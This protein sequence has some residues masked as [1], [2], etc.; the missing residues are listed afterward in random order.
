MTYNILQG[1][2]KEVLATIPDNFYDGCFCDPP[3]GLHFMGKKWDYD[4]P[5]KDTW[6]EVYRILKPG[7]Y[8]LAFGG[9]RT[10]HRLVCEIEDAGFIVR[11]SLTWLFGS[12]FP[13]SHNISKDMDKRG[14]NNHISKEIGI[15]IKEARESRGLTIKECDD[16][17]CNSSTNWSWFEGR[18]AGQRIPS[19]ELFS[20]LCEEWPELLPYFEQVKEVNREIIAVGKR[21]VKESTVM[22]HSVGEEYDITTST[23]DPAKVWEGYGT[24]I[25]PAY[26]PI[27]LCQK[28]I[29][30]TYAANCLKWGCGA[31]NID[32]C[33]IGIE[34]I[35][36]NNGP[37]Q[38]AVG[39]HGAEEKM[40]ERSGGIRTPGNV[41]PGLAGKNNKEWKPEKISTHHAPS[42][43]FA[44][45]EEGRG[46][47]TTTYEEHVGRFPANLILDDESA[48]Q[49]D[50]QVGIKKSGHMKKGTK[51]K[52][53][54]G[55]ALGTFNPGEI[56]NE[57]E[58]SIGGVSR[59]FYCAKVNAK[60]RNAGLEDAPDS[61]LA[62]SGGAQNAVNEDKDYTE[63]Q[64]IG[65][66]HVS[67][68]KNNHPT[69]KPISLCQYL[70]RLILPPDRHDK[71]NLRKILI[72]FAGSGSEVIGALLSS[73]DYV[74][75]IEM[76]ET[77]VN[78]AR[79]RCEYW[80]N[81]NKKENNENKEKNNE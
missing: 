81:K 10:Y 2:V 74:E 46:S 55:N 22:F 18:P 63:C 24:A 49:L 44:G 19:D 11:D 52:G 31:L 58:A 64:G 35:H 51:T 26:E 32:G 30:G 33:R 71:N 70:S 6:Q 1:D 14:G 25:K 76:E 16:K 3:Y 78:I 39:N 57:I 23:T 4:V 7:A 80:E 61:I 41:L 69:M 8:L 77:Y 9:P 13:K 15:K 56:K 47:D 38:W 50:L 67:S 34:E 21:V 79:Q 42:G 73:W 48:E 45:G 65:L 62:R 66:N 59:F 60:E 75:G 37:G 28:P 43:T 20:L 53:G 68:V 36:I 29:E 17:F 12:G 5:K 54:Q 72:P 27:V 40:L